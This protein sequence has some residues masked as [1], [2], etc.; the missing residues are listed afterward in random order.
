[1]ESF[2]PFAVSD[3]VRAKAE[4]KLAKDMKES[5]G[6]GYNGSFQKGGGLLHGS[7][8]EFA[9][10]EM[11]GGE[12][13]GTPDYDI[14][15]N[16]NRLEIKD[17]LTTNEPNRHYEVHLCT[18]N[19]RQKCDYYV[20][21]FL[22]TNLKRGWIVAFEEKQKFVPGSMLMRKGQKF[23]NGCHV[24]HDCCVKKITAVQQIRILFPD[25]HAETHTALKELEEEEEAR[26][27]ETD[28][29]IYGAFFRGKKNG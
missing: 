3:E 12:H 9:V 28:E 24:L 29:D 18:Y 13:H 17:H 10:H 16:G 15:W 25:L 14:L 5:G 4:A 6:R 23:S 7:I 8:A 27:E 26:K 11:I 20:W 2:I 21:V 1:M 19:L 22:K